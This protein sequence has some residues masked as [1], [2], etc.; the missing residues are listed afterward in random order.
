MVSPVSIV[1]WF[2]CDGRYA[3]SSAFSLSDAAAGVCS[4]SVHSDPPVKSPF[5]NNW[6]I[7]TLSNVIHLAVIGHAISCIIRHV[8]SLVSPRQPGYSTAAQRPKFCCCCCCWQTN[9]SALAATLTA[10]YV[11]TL[12]YQLMLLHALWNRITSAADWTER[13]VSRISCTGAGRCHQIYCCYAQS[14]LFL[15]ADP[16]LDTGRKDCW[17]NWRLPIWAQP[18]QS[19]S[20]RATIYMELFLENHIGLKKWQTMLVHESSIKKSHWHKKKCFFSH[21][22][23]GSQFS[24]RCLGLISIDLIFDLSSRSQTS[25]VVL[26]WN[27]FESQLICGTLDLSTEKLSQALEKDWRNRKTGTGKEKHTSQKLWAV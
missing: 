22:M 24:W 6:C 5:A 14:E 12:Q 23:Q 4:T 27:R 19:R 1:S 2:H 3:L 13:Q 20:L 8:A 18:H 17:Q 10:V 21:P 7:Q 9:R 11:Q 26:R 25:S 15:L 16:E